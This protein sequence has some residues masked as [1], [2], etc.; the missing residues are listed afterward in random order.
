[1]EHFYFLFLF[2]SKYSD[3]IW[4][5]KPHLLWW[6]WPKSK[7]TDKYAFVFGKNDIFGLEGDF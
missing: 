6:Y 7:C 5:T 4:S 2:K 1:M 3:I